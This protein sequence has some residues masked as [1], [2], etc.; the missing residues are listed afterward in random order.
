MTAEGEGSRTE[1]KGSRGQ[2][3]KEPFHL[4]PSNPQQSG[5]TTKTNEQ[6]A[7]CQALSEVRTT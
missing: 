2:S 1:K 7:R 5:N 4:V 3:E 6:P